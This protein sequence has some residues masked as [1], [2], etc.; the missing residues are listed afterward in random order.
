ME[1]TIHNSHELNVLQFAGTHLRHAEELARVTGENFNVFKILRIDR[2]EVRT[3]SPILGELLNPQGAH[4][5]RS[6]F[7][8]LFLS[9]IAGSKSSDASF[10][11]KV[12]EFHADTATL[13]TEVN[14]GPVDTNNTEGGIIDVV[15]TDT[16]NRSH[17]FIENKIDANDQKN[18][19]LRY[20]NH[21]KEAALFYLT[22]N[23]KPPS[24]CSKGGGG[25]YVHPISYGKDILRWLELCRKESACLPGVRETISQY[26]HLIE[27][28]TGQSTITRMNTAL[29]SD[30]W[31]AWDRL[32]ELNAETAL[33]IASLRFGENLKSKLKTM[34]EIANKISESS[35]Q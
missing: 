3:H 7:L 13:E 35:N 17:I 28:L 14:I 19:L 16:K 11:Q 32:V 24:E 30:W 34:A 10:I 4:G 1:T 15:L 9:S 33:A 27:E 8:K 26:I 29:I 22:L 25:F 20:H 12:S 21:D 31:P 6:L 2:A 5:Q 23:G 18:Q